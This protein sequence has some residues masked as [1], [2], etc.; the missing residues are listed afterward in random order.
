M[1]KLKN[2]QNEPVVKKITDKNL[3]KPREKNK[4]T[5]LSYKEQYLL[6]NLP[7]E[8]EKLEQENKSIEIALGNPNLYIDD[9]QK[10]DELS[11]SLAANKIKLE[12]LENQ[13]LELQIRADELAN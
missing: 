6:Q 9:P 5:K 3:S 12:E 2:K 8:I 10:F 1:E 4:T 13:W 7:S 11:S